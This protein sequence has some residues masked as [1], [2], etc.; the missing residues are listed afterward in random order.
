MSPVCRPVHSIYLSQMA[1]KIAP[2]L[3]SYPWQ[4]FCIILGHL[5][6]YTPGEGQYPSRQCPLGDRRQMASRDVALTA[7]VGK[8][9]LLALYSVFEPFCF[10]PCSG[11]PSLHLLSTRIIRHFEGLLPFTSHCAELPEPGVGG[12]SALFFGVLKVSL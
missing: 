10:P 1:F 11:D 5:F 7:C 12:I 3:H 8:V 6:D 9:I 4:L 2:W